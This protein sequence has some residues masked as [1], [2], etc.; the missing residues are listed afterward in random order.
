MI[1]LLN[2]YF[3][4]SDPE[5]FTVDENNNAISPAV[6]VH[7]GRINPLGGEPVHFILDDQKDFRLISDGVAWEV[8]NK[9]PF[10]LDKPLE[11][12]N[13]VRNSIERLGEI[14]D[15]LG[16]RIFTKPTV[17]INLPFYKKLLAEDFELIYTG[18][19]SGCDEDK[20]AINTDYVCKKVDLDTYPYRHGGGHIHI[21]T[22]NTFLHD[23]AIPVIR[24]LAITVGN[25]TIVNSSEPELEKLRCNSYGNPGRF[26]FQKYPNNFFGVEYRSPSN[27]WINYSNATYLE[28]IENLKLALRNIEKGKFEK[29]NLLEE[30]I[31]AFKS[32]DRGLSQNILR[33]AW[34]K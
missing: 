15:K 4:G 25:F 33:R 31:V 23:L 8:T 6:L 1:K 28:M 5:F 11:M 9:K 10:D 20:D 30:T 13:N 3:L 29:L 24:M 16:L 34:S 7:Q 18:F 26:R 14:A 27:S 22:D 21:S 17:E 19:V 12:L 32:Y 2:K